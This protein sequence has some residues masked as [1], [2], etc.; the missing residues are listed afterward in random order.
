MSSDKNSSLA[1]DLGSH[2]EL[3]RA[4]SRCCASA[5]PGTPLA[6]P[7][8]SVCLRAGA[9]SRTAGEWDKRSGMGMPGILPALLVA[10]RMAA[11]GPMNRPGSA[12]QR[13]PKSGGLMFLER[14]TQRW[15][16]LVVRGILSIAFGALTVAAPPAAVIAMVFIFGIYAIVDGLTALSVLLSPLAPERGG[17]LL[18]LG[19]L[20]SVA[21]GGGALAWPGVPRI[22]LFLVIG[23]WAIR[24]GRT[25]I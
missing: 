13:W 5:V 4:V 24:R 12:T 17:W 25:E 2:V 18:G 1:N 19:G 8:V 22:A 14:A 3:G 20:V 23:R 16:T 15:W 6:K 21:A 7:K 9:S 11:P 10:S